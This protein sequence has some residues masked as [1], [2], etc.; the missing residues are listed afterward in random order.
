MPAL[1]RLALENFDG[2]RADLDRYGI[3]CDF[4]PTGELLALTDAYQDSVARGGARRRCARFGHEVTVLD[5]AAMQRRG[6]TRPP[7]VGGVWDH[8]GAGIL[9]PGKLAAGLRDAALRAGVRV[10]EHSA[11]HHIGD[12][13][14][15]RSTRHGPGRARAQGPARHERLSAAA[16]ARSSTTSCRST[17]TRW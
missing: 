14:H 15:G 17:T 9:D 2:L 5:G 10:Y 13:L 12:D 11:V 6:R 4:E 3:D 7:T 8:T 16:C 1:E